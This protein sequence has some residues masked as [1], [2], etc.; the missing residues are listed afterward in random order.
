ML[1]GRPLDDEAFL[2]LEDVLAHQDDGVRSRYQGLGF[3]GDKGNRI[4][5]QLVRNGILE[6]QE[7]RVGRTYKVLLRITPQ[8][9]QRLGL[10]KSMERGSLAHEYWKRFYASCLRSQRYEV[11]LEAPRKPGQPGWVDVLAKNADET[12]GVEIETG[13]SDIL[14][15][16]KQDLL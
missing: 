15:N 9:R 12:V 13:K 1:E 11:Q 6:E 5:N 3:S 8:A 4:K 16:V 7:V 2:F 10:K 14:G